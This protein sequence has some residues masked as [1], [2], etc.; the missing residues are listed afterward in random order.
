MRTAN[1]GASDNA[2]QEQPKASSS[3][4]E[5]PDAFAMKILCHGSRGLTFRSEGYDIAVG[6]RCAEA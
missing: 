2:A 1:G 4:K 3:G 6:T 5:T